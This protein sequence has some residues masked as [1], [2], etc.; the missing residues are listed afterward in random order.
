MTAAADL[1]RI[2]ARRAAAQAGNQA[3]ADRDLKP[4]NVTQTPAEEITPRPSPWA[5]TLF[6]LDDDRY[7]RR[8]P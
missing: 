3:V 2:R 5:S 6:D 7:W 8:Q 1:A 4:S